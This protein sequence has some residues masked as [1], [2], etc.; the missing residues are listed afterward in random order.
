MSL[1]KRGPI[2]PKMISLIDW[3][4]TIFLLITV[5]AV[6]VPWIPGMPS[7]GLDGSWVFGV[8]QAM[9][10]GLSFGKEIIFTFGPYAAIYTK[11]YHPATDGLML[12]GSLYLALHYSIVLIV[13]LKNR[14]WRWSLAYGV[15]LVAIVVYSRD[16]LLFSYPLLIGLLV[17]RF[18]SDQSNRSSWT[19]WIL[20]WLFCSLGL[21][22]LIK[23]SLILLYGFVPLWCGWFLFLHKKRVQG[24]VAL[25]MPLGALPL[26]WIASGSSLSNLPDYFISIGDIISGYT[27][28]MASESNREILIYPFFCISLAGVIFLQKK[29]ALFSKIFLLGLFGIFL[30]T[31]FKAGFVRHDGHAIAAAIALLIASV[32]LPCIIDS[33]RVVI[34]FLFGLVGSTIIESHYI[35]LLEAYRN[36]PSTY[37]SAWQGITNRTHHSNS[38]NADFERAVLSLKE[39]AGFPLLAGTTDIYSY[40]QSYLIASGNCWNPRPIFQSYSAYTPPLAEKNREHLSGD[41]APDNIFF[42]IEPIDGRIPSMEDGASW[43]AL[44]T[45][46]KPK[47]WIHEF[48]LLKKREGFV[49]V[50]PTFL[51]RGNYSLG[52]VVKLPATPDLLFVQIEIRQTLLGRLAEILLKPTELHIVVTFQNGATREDRLISKMASSGFLISPWIKNTQDFELLYHNINLLDQKRPMV[53][54]VKPERWGNLFWKT[55]YSVI[56][57][58]LPAPHFNL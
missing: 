4:V 36:I 46:Y 55:K 52:E 43:P 40:D 39:K 47:Q 37:S 57:K 27:E 44:L 3:S 18:I 6:F 53:F 19:R 51:K 23:G 12:A 25:V 17:Y 22:P 30:F 13:L 41:H 45:G 29:I 48:L 1:E 34:I 26:F 49:A 58:T 54:L 2:I 50:E 8:N 9:A 35:N 5:F 20:P 38:F 32:L 56:F 11:Q 24:I 14:P 31:A 15:A 33:P 16:V 28:A 10:Q 21:L 42:K 7:A